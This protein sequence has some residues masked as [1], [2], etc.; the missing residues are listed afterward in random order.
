MYVCLHNYKHTNT[1]FVRFIKKNLFLSSVHTKNLYELNSIFEFVNL[2]A[3]GAEN[4]HNSVFYP[5]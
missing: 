3:L 1:H 2:I 4:C 5:K